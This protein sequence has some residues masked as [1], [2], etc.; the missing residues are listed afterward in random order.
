M[1]ELNPGDVAEWTVVDHVR[2]GVLVTLAGEPSRRA[3]I[4]TT[5]LPDDGPRPEIGETLRA[6]VLV[7]WHDGRLS[8]TA[9]TQA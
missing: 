4:A 7:P 5:D 9:L 2:W 6:A 8:L 3:S 1:Q